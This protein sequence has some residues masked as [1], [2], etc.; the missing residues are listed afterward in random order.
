MSPIFGVWYNFEEI[1]PIHNPTNHLQISTVE[2]KS[3]TRKISICTRNLLN[4]AQFR[5]NLN[6][7]IRVKRI[8]QAN[9]KMDH[10]NHTN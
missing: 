10:Y 3:T 4:K 5:D 1:A 6:S 7:T 8:D 9:L 2:S